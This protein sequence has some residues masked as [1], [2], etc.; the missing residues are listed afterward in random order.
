MPD[1]DIGKKISE[2]RS[3]L[4]FTQ[5]Y[6]SS[7]LGVARST[8]AEMESGQ[9]RVTAE[10]LY[11]LA[12]MLG[13]PL[14]YFFSQSNPEYSFAF[15]V[16]GKGSEEDAHKALVKLDN[17]LNEIRSLERY[18]GIAAKTRLKQYQIDKWRSP[19][20]AGRNIAQSERARLGL[21]NLP[22]PNIRD[23]LERQMNLFAFGDYFPSGGL[24]GAFGSDGEH[25]ALLIN[26]AHIRGR[27]NFTLAHE[28]G[29]AVVSKVGAHVEFRNSTDGD[30]EMFADSFASNFLIPREVI[31]EVIETNDVDLPRITSDEVLMLASQFG[32]S[33]LAMLARL[34]HFGMIDPKDSNRLKKEA[35]PISRS[36]QLGLPDPREE[37]APLPMIYQRMAF[38]S[39]HKQSISRSRLAEFLGLDADE[40]YRRY[41]LWADEIIAAPRSGEAVSATHD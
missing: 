10:E 20:V 15:R 5:A 12:D 37:F 36:K 19:V 26:V 14:I 25:S 29:H 30:E 2:A 4:G 23:I 21:G 32:V 22:V 8:L 31:E 1:I 9:R 39:F 13:R 7:K 17:R 28:F 3:K 11:S 24:S 27:V 38:L 35:K 16:T 18:S 33:F 41:L 34:E 6:L 40:A